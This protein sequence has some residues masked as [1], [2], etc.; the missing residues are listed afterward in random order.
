MDER[1]GKREMRRDREME[2]EK[3]TVRDRWWRDR[4]EKTEKKRDREIQRRGERENLK[5]SES[6]WPQENWGFVSDQISGLEQITVL[7]LLKHLFL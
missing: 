4:G 1:Q 2:I 6:Q 5:A 3:Q 7:V